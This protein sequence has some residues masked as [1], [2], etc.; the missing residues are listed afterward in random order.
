MLPSFTDIVAR[1]PSQVWII[2]AVILGLGLMQ[3]RTRDVPRSRVM[4]LPLAMIGLSL[5]TIVSGFQPWGA[6]IGFWAAGLGIAF[7]IDAVLIR[8]PRNVSFDAATDKFRVPGSITPMAIMLAIFAVNYFVGVTR[9]LTPARLADP[10]FRMLVCGGLGILSGLLVAR[11]AR[12][13]RA[14]K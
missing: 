2:L 9:A 8:S 3:M 12:T 14:A 10:D 1:T 13:L 7:G 4:I 6:P 5:Y 11:A